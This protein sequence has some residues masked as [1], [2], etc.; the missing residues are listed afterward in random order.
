MYSKR[1][2]IKDDQTIKS[3]LIESLST[4]A[5]IFKSNIKIKK[6]EKEV[7]CK[8]SPEVWR[9]ITSKECIIEIV[10]YGIDE[11]KAVNDLVDLLEKEFK[12]EEQQQYMFFLD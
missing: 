6:V 2:V 8:S 3:W 5:R 9:M 12:E 7:D 4:K 11:K 1:V 10:A